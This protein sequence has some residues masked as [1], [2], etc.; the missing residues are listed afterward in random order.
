MVDIGTSPIR[1]ASNGL[2]THGKPGQT[3]DGANA[4]T[5]HSNQS[6]RKESTDAANKNQ[7]QSTSTDQDTMAPV[8][9]YQKHASE[10][11]EK[12]N[13]AESV[14]EFSQAADHYR[15]ALTHLQDAAEEV[16]TGNEERVKAI[17]SSVE[18]TQEKLGTVTELQE[19]RDSLTEALQ[20]A[21]RSFQDAVAAFVTG[22]HTLAKIRFRQARDGFETAQETIENSETDLFTTPITVS[23]D[24]QRDLSSTT[25]ET[26]D[27]F[28]E[29]TVDLLAEMNVED[30][31]DLIHSDGK[32]TPTTVTVLQTAD[33]ISDS[34]TIDLT[35]VSWWHGRDEFT[36]SNL[37]E[38][39]R[40]REQGQR[41][42]EYS[43]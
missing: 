33:E 24:V 35:V 8:D 34:E 4:T 41:G 29:T 17:E 18:I 10:E 7:P 2:G 16:G 15:N 39:S 21:E 5:Q 19:E 42:F 32:L 6:D 14:D 23:I 38:I 9:K 22:S 30:T 1:M 26:V 25:L 40:R 12:A 37:E 43:N 27:R 36:F 31:S 13:H 28:D 11:I 3:T 20:T